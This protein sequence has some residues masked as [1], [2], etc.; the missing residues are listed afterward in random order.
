MKNEGKT[1][2]LIYCLGLNTNPLVRP[3]FAIFR[4]AQLTMHKHDDVAHQETKCN[5]IG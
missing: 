4:P 1:T 5:L 3:H 2:C